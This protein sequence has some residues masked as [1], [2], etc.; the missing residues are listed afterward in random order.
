[1][2]I[3][4]K[5]LPYLAAFAAGLFVAWYVT[6]GFAERDMAQFERDLYEA[7]A[8]KRT[9]AAK[10]RNAREKIEELESAKIDKSEGE[11]KQTVRT[12]T[13]EVVKYVQSPDAGRC[14]LPRSWVQLYNES[15]GIGV[16]S[17]DTS[18]QPA[19]GTP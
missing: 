14:V 10:L 3:S 16:P 11:H 7:Q 15:L 9:A 17:P 8:A 5:L 19:D 6:N 1:M 2:N 4:S 18:R 13:K 12:V